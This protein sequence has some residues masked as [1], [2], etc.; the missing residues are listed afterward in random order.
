MIL[1]LMKR[2]FYMIILVFVTAI[3]SMAFSLRTLPGS[4]QTERGKKALTVMA[5]NIHHANPPSKPQYIDVDAIVEVIRKQSPDLVAL[6]EVDVNT[7]RS[8][9]IDQAKVIAEK[10]G[11]YYFF[12]KAIDYDGGEYGQA[13]LSK[14]PISD[15]KI[16]RLPS[17]EGSGGEPR[18][19][20]T[21]K[22]E[23][24]KRTFIR[25]GTTHLDAQR[26]PANRLLQVEKLNDIAAQ[27]KFPLVVAGDFNAAE[28]TEPLQIL[29]KEFIS[30]C[31]N[32]PF[33]IPVINPRRTIDFIMMDKKTSWE[34]VSHQVID[35][36][37]ASDHLPVV[38]KLKLR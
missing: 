18:I 30:T 9:N 36:Q 2:K 32:C 33:T 24:G 3:S 20:A 12:A 25:F 26:D 31:E 28:H 4:D 6:Q 37:Y 19:L 29:G 27:E 23:V 16:H 35:E 17:K 21:A 11:M 38:A 13:I 10:L 22:V 15:E 1:E 5:Y 7:G 8:G 34:I 14:F